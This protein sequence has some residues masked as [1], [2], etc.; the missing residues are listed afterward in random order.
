MLYS[1]LCLEPENRFW[2]MVSFTR[3]T[4]RLTFSS[5]AI[6]RA[7]STCARLLA[8][9]I[10]ARAASATSRSS[11]APTFSS[12]W[13]LTSDSVASRPVGVTR[14]AVS[15]SIPSRSSS[16]AIPATV[17]HTR[18]PL[19]SRPSVA[20]IIPRPAERVIEAA[21][22]IS[23]LGWLPADECSPRRRAGLDI[24]PSCDTVRPLTPAAWLMALRDVLPTWAAGV[25]IARHV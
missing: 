9:R 20:L 7:A 2:R 3:S 16:S 17:T 25:I 5:T 18:L 12:A 14:S 10:C 22:S 24:L 19:R 4:T 13:A 21:A 1:F 6:A 23:Y 11:N 15:R 8:W